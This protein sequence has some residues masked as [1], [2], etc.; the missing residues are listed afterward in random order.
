MPDPILDEINLTTLP[1]INDVCI[2][3]LFFLGSVLQAHM[4]V[5]CLVPF[6]GGAFSR[7]TF[8]FRPL[9]GGAY[10]KGVGG[11][12][13]TKPT[14]LGGTVFDPRFYV[15]MIVE[16][17]EDIMVLND[18]DLAVFDLVAVD[19]ANAYQT[20]SA[21]MALDIQQ[22]GQIG[23]R[24]IN[25]NGWV[26][27]LN[28]GFVPSWDG[29]VYSTYGTA[30]RNGVV[31]RAL[32]GNV[33]W[34]GNPDGSV[35]SIQY[36]QFN[37]MYNLAR[38]GQDEP[39]LWV[40]N[41]PLVSAVENRMQPQQRLDQGTQS[42]RDPY[43]G[44]T[45]F[46]FKNAIVMADDYFPSALGYPYSDAS[47]S[48]LG[49][50]LTGVVAFNAPGGSSANS[51]AS[52]VPLGNGPVNISIGEVGCF[53]NTSRIKFR[54]HNSKEFGFEPTD[55]IRDPASTR[56][57][58]QLKAAVNMEFTAPWTGVQGYGWAGN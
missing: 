57:A 17:L 40:S 24:T 42:I 11:F 29:N 41:K 16:Y 50:N 53:F 45:G 48:G 36:P 38:R 44:A 21:I 35:G 56:I 19:M 54:V 9:Y 13:L 43:F 8:M 27:A 10:A 22:N 12:N 31:N 49:N 51:P 15:V 28:D 30:P 18:G 32:N 23:S 25:I 6:K 7:N 55:F 20:M 39:D 14:T 52:F 58:S 3:D 5:K 33:Y 1:E 46:K 2:E 37:A 26:E 47:N 4:R 34:G